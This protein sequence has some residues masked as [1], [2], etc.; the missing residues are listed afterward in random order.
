[1]Q[2]LVVLICGFCVFGRGILE[3]FESRVQVYSHFY[4]C[5]KG[6]LEFWVWNLSQFMVSDFLGEVILN[7]PWTLFPFWSSHFKIKHKDHCLFNL[8]VLILSIATFLWLWIWSFYYSQF[9]TFV[10][11]T[12]VWCMVFTF[13]K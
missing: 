6:I 4:C 13:L 9:S 2:K 5:G 12:Q 10:H 7:R 8:V 1:L 3:N 11:F